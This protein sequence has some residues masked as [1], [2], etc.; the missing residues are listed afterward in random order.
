M[1]FLILHSFCVF[2]FMLQAASAARLPH[3]KH[4]HL[5][6]RAAP[7]S[8]PPLVF[9]HYMLITRPPNGDYTNDINL[10]KEAG[11]DAFVVNYG[12]WDVDWTQQES[13]LKD[14]YSAAEKLGFKLFLSID[15]TSV[16][17]P[18]MVT[19]L[20][21]Q[22]SQSPAQL[23]VNDSIMLSSFE[24]NSPAWNWQTDVIDKINGKVTLLPG[25]LSDDAS[26]VFSASDRGAGAFTWI[27]PTKTVQQEASTDDQFAAQRNQTGKLWMAGIGSWFFKRFD[28][29]NNWSQ[30]QDEGMFF[31]RWMHLLQLKPNY[32]ELLTWNDWGESSY[33]GPADVTNSCP[34]CYWAKLDHCAF[35]KMSAIFIQAFK[36]GSTNFIASPEYEDV[37]FFYR[38]Q[39]STT[40]GA[41][42]I[43]ALPTDAQTLKNNVYVVSFLN[44]PASISLQ[45]GTAAPT[46]FDA[47]AGINLKAIPWT[48][49]NQTLTANRAG[50]ATSL[51]TKVGP[52]IEGR[53]ES[54]NGNVVA[55]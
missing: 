51:V 55:L 3:L 15:C 54:Y 4:L 43:L 44:S 9:A 12:G 41:L 24:T 22:Y 23:K 29:S 50:N 1:A 31:D 52:A 11:I 6:R 35:L 34:T 25:T 42:D 28:E 20:V 19:S 27:H 39:P 47:P 14:F 16:T 26:S 40:M 8:T 38:T 2:L 48:L 37:F 5:H 33:L 10:A 36:S 46:T 53:L 30:A 13:N 17:D 49:G 32:I 45:G 21:N 18:S 7:A